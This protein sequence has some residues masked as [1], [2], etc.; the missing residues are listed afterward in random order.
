M[1][2]K[3]LTF[4]LLS[5]WCVFYLLM[6]F[7]TVCAAGCH[8]ITPASVVTP[9]SHACCSNNLKP[10]SEIKASLA[11]VCPFILRKAARFETEAALS[12]LEEKGKDRPFAFDIA[13]LWNSAEIT[14][15]CSAPP[16]LPPIHHPDC[17]GIH[18]ILRI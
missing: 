7:A 10:S 6:P 2:K 12:P 8:G 15:I 17:S 9:A 16:C 4:P 1:L 3:A 11:C 18:S 13:P 5:V 14:E